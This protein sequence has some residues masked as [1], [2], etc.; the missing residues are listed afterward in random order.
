MFCIFNIITGNYIK[1]YRNDSKIIYF[2]SKEEA[3]EHLNVVRA[4]EAMKSIGMFGYEWNEFTK[5]EYVVIDLKDEVINNDSF[6]AY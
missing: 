2:S 3:L 6:L 1:H 5:E 4:I